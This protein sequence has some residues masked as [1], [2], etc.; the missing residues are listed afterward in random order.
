MKSD[1]VKFL[2]FN[3]FLILFI[4]ISCS[5]EIKKDI[6]P[7]ANKSTPAESTL[8]K[9]SEEIEKKYLKEGFISR[10]ISG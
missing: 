3:L 8:L 10:N 5:K 7:G 1:A 4:F 2:L 6:K 9:N